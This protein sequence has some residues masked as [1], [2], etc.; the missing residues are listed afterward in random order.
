MAEILCI[1][2]LI[3]TLIFML[4]LVV[5]FVDKINKRPSAINLR[6]LIIAFFVVFVFFAGSIGA[7]I[8]DAAETQPTAY[9]TKQTQ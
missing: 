8:M 7:A 3:A 9:Q 6:T 5:F 2:W 4:L 1:L